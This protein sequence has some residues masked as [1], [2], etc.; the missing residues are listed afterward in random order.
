MTK[1]KEKVM[2]NK[3]NE[4][5]SLRTKTDEASKEKCKV[6]E[7]DLAD[8][9][10][11]ECYSKIEQETNGID[12][13]LGGY[14]SGNLWRLK[15]KL[16]PKSRDPPTA[17]LDQHGVIQTDEDIL[18][19]ISKDAYRKR[20]ENRK[21]KPGL[22]DMQQMKE[23]LCKKRL[24][25]AQRNKTPP[26]TM[27]ELLQVLGHPKKDAARDPI[28]YANE[29]FH[30]E[31]AGTDLKNAV[32]TLLNLIKQTQT[33]PDKMEWCNISSIWK[34][35]GPMN[36]FDSYRGIFRITVL[37]NILDRLIY[38]DEYH[39]VD[40]NLS[41]SNVGGRKGRN[42]RDNIFVI[43]AILN[44]ITKQNADAH[45]L[46]IY[47]VEKCFDSMWLHECV[48]VL[49]EAGLNNDKRPLLFMSNS[50]AQ[51]A[52]KTATG[53]TDRISILKIVM[54]GTVWGSLFVLLSWIN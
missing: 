29:L 31:V 47:D 33:Y 17:M 50:T 39:K 19:E 7:N 21:I 9:Y 16:F 15:K 6:L 45:D 25:E 32:L 28:G 40:Q 1:H 54:Q 46:Q 20:L 12:V 23:N 51:V 35:K 52:N 36:N 34:R 3:Y 24:E 27:E 5:N 22:E 11:E 10:G 48:N 43:N 41:D 4:W 2:E 44:S 42:V 30:P 13:T 49:F 18:K 37:R 8:S 53:I 38:N 14:N 26:W